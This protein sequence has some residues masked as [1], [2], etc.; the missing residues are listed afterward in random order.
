M[1]SHEKS[2]GGVREFARSRPPQG[3]CVSYFCELCSE[4]TNFNVLVWGSPQLR[5]TLLAEASSNGV[6]APFP[7]GGSNRSFNM[8]STS[9]WE[10]RVPET[11]AVACTRPDC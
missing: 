8:C 10:G 11:T 1:G 5:G 4:E 6:V 3:N 9:P 7:R 2:D